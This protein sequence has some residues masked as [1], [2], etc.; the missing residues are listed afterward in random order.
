[1]ENFNDEEK[2]NEI[3]KQYEEL[4]ILQNKCKCA[5]CDCWINKNYIKRHYTTKTHNKKSLEIWENPELQEKFI[6]NNLNIE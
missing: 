6:N 4:M 2:Y 1:M 5:I 3:K